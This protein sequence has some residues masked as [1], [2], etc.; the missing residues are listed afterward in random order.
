MIMLRL[1]LLIPNFL[2]AVFLAL[3]CAAP[4]YAKPASSG[5]AP[6]RV[7]LV[8]GNNDYQH[9]P[10]LT[11]AVPDAKVMAQEFRALGFDVIEKTN[12][13]QR[14]MKAAVREFV[15]RIGNGGV[16]AFFY[17]GH[18]VQDGGNNFLLPVDIGKLGDPSALPDD[19]IELNSD[20][21]GRIGQAGAKFSLLVIDACRDNPFPRRAGRSVGGTRGLT[22]APET[23]EGMIVVYSAGV[24][25]QALDRLDESDRSPNGLFTREFV[26]ELRKPGL[27]VAEMVRNVRQRV[28]DAAA[29]VQHEQTPAI[30]IQ[31]DRFYLVA[32]PPLPTPPV[33]PSSEDALWAQLDSDKPCEY[34]A[35]LEEYPAGKF[36]ALARIR[37]RDCVPSSRQPPR[38]AVAMVKPPVPQAR[39]VDL[40]AAAPAELPTPK[41][42]VS[43]STAVA[44]DPRREGETGTVKVTQEPPRAA[45]AAE[46]P[47][48]PALP[49]ESVSASKPAKTAAESPAPAKVVA[50]APA[51]T[52]GKP[53]ATTA[54]KGKSAPAALS[55]PFSSVPSPPSAQTK[56]DGSATVSASSFIE[57]PLPSE[58]KAAPVLAPPP[59]PSAAA[60][61]KDSPPAKPAQLEIVAPG[62]ETNTQLAMLAPAKD[63]IPSVRSKGE[64]GDQPDLRIGDAWT[65]QRLD[66]FTKNVVGSWS[67]RVQ[68]RSGSSARIESTSAVGRSYSTGLLELDVS[69]WRI[70]SARVVEGKPIPLAFPLGVGKTWE[71]TYRRKRND[72]AGIT[73]YSVKARVEGLEKIETPA[74]V[75]EA[76]KVVHKKIYETSSGGKNWSSSAEEI[77]W[78]APDARRWVRHDLIDRTSSGRIADQYREELVKL[79]LRP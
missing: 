12:V 78:Y 48:K 43:T 41:A 24:G 10:K 29:K 58:M 14:S 67:D 57:L 5:D 75:F 17:A 69:S 33:L 54:P 47:T 71:Y 13:D 42:P 19:A 32:P 70:E 44:P 28:K 11:N 55:G 64:P 40:P 68:A 37:A 16:G 3:G 59:R 23:P 1:L 7:A 39:P 35:Y 51:T 18:G 31:A 79:E 30:Y 2:L 15:K 25:Q 62:A 66:L 73:T 52:K 63:A 38:E 27:E 65:M 74:G 9:V 53:A 22:A 34:M 45:T 20:V 50:A 4:A 56:R 61:R 49:S 46:V 36:A 6:A 8:I 26:V 60:A 76:F 21:M 72:D 77:Y